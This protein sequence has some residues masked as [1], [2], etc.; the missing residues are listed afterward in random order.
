MR[1]DAVDRNDGFVQAPDAAADVCHNPAAAFACASPETDWIAS[2][3]LEA[4]LAEEWCNG[5]R[6]PRARWGPVCPGMTSGDYTHYHSPEY[7][8]QRERRRADA[9]ATTATRRAG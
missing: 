9:E 6:Q 7:W 8:K 2:Q 1:R 4:A 3:E 5:C